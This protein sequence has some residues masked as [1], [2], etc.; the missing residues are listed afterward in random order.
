[1]RVK[2][3][4]KIL[5]WLGAACILF[6]IL[7]LAFAGYVAVLHR[8]T[9]LLPS[10]TGSYRVGRNEFDWIDSSRTDPFSDRPGEK[11]EILVWVWYPADAAQGGHAAPY[12]PPAW[13]KARDA[14]AGIGKYI[15]S[16]TSAIQTHSFENIPVSGSQT[17]YPV[18]LMQPGM[19]PG[20]ADYTIFAEN[21]ASYG[22]IVVGINQA[23]TSNL[24][25]FPDG[26]AVRR[27][28]S[29]TIPDDADAATVDSDAGRI[30]KVWTDDAV[31]VMDQLQ[32]LNA[33]PSGLFHNRLDLAHIGLFG[34]SFGGATAA[35]VCKLDRRCKAGA[36]LDGTLFS[37]QAKG[38]FQTPFMFMAEDGC[39]KDCATMHES[40]TDSQADA[41]YL[42]V[43]GTG[44]FNFSDLPLRWLPP[45]RFLFRQAGYIGAIG[46]RRGLEISN[47]YL[48]AFFDRYLK[49]INSDLLQSSSSAYPEV[50]FEM[51]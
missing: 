26:R 10:P 33:D 11:R 2:P 47:A 16:D 28:E 13:I 34:H 46:L 25:V 19:G 37:Y 35:S 48:V 42:S 41:S 50:Q 39:G 17:T 45:V 9:L 38:T 27:S 49:N 43:L 21:L 22:Y 5:K 36:D 23:Y 3:I 12:L 15:E 6:V 4:K 7:G 20:P 18:I 1:M 29:G 51:H 8:R 30:G 14:D 44:H 40:F 32:A 31:F 24:V